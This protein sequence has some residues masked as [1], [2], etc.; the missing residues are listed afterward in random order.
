MVTTKRPDWLCSKQMHSL[1]CSWG[2]VI[3]DWWRL[4]F[5]EYTVCRKQ[6]ED[7]IF[8]RNQN[9][10]NC[11]LS[12][13][14]N[15]DTC[16]IMQRLMMEP[17]GPV[18]TF[19]DFCGTISRVFKK[20]LRHKISHSRTKITS[21]ML[22]MNS[23]H[24][25]LAEK[26]FSGARIWLI[27]IKL[28]IWHRTLSRRQSGKNR[29]PDALTCTMLRRRFRAFAPGPLRLK[30]NTKFQGWAIA[31]TVRSVEVLDVRLVVGRKEVGD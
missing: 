17:V 15:Y 27:N 10:F 1:S 11:T 8:Q 4:S 9:T 14:C 18:L 3:K 21:V 13:S 5:D 7:Y 23:G 22:S 2:G 26:I 12:S 20:K 24:N 28:K 19:L 6:F 25:L 29:I 30:L 31:S 16:T